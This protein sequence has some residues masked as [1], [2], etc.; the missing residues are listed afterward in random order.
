VYKISRQKK[1]KMN[2]SY[3]YIYIYIYADY[4]IV[5][6]VSMVIYAEEHMKAVPILDE[7]DKLSPWSV[8]NEE[9]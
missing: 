4:L 2:K 1:I 7:V 3:I 8:D 9:K 6:I 5:K